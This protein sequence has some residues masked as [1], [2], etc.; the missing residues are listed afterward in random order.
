MTR[1]QTIC[2]RMVLAQGSLQAIARIRRAALRG[3]NI[4]DLKVIVPKLDKL[5]AQQHELLAL[6]GEA[7]VQ[8]H[9]ANDADILPGAA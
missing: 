8:H 3:E 1:L 9:A 4:G 2:S 7:L 6:T 5:A